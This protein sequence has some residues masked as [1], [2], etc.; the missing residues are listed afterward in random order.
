[1]NRNPDC[2]RR[3]PIVLAVDD[4]PANLD[5]LVEHLH[6]EDIELTVALSGEEGLELARSLRPD[7]ILLDVMM[8]GMDGF[9]VCRRLKSEPELKDIPVLFLTAVDEEVEIERG[10]ALGA[11][12]YVHKPFSLPILKARMRNHLALKRKSDE[13][14]QLACTDGLTGVANRRH[15]DLSFDAEWLRAQRH[16]QSLSLVV[17]D[18]DH[19]KRFN[20]HY[21]HGEGD[22]CLKQ[23]AQA[24]C[25]CIRRPGDL[26]A[27][28][29]GEEFVALLPDTGAEAARAMA[30]KMWRSVAALAIVHAGNPP[31]G[32]VSISLG[33]ATATPQPDATAAA[34]LAKA[35]E[36]LYQAKAAGR[37]RIVG[38]GRDAG[39]VEA[40]RGSRP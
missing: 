26:L 25:G 12:D 35:D 5:V 27:R 32:R 37:N 23:V 3:A 6:Q 33:V 29:G 13:L 4:V 28:Y 1:M 21:G 10:F 19:F 36:R 11:V 2:T 16:R 40:R 7:L 14:A 38:E 9:E 17:I 18:V 30:E 31:D 8:P 39:C 22:T 34:L 24:L 15:F 20:D